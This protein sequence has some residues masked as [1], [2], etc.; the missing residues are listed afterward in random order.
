M[1]KN[2][3][4]VTLTLICVILVTCAVSPHFIPSTDLEPMQVEDP[5]PES[6]TIEEQ[7]AW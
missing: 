5:D 3:M 7:E 2:V 6:T 4:I 1:K